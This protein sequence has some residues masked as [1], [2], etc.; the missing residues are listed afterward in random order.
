VLAEHAADYFHCK[1]PSPFMTQVSP[2]REEKRHVIPAVTHIDGTARV[3]TVER[4]ASPL[5]WNLIDAFYRLT[6][7]PVV[8]NTSFNVKGQPIV[9]TPAEAVETFMQT[10]LDALICGSYLILKPVRSNADQA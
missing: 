9:N 4:A 2:V 8:L 10:S 6:S 7:V 1:G 5:Y 3:Q